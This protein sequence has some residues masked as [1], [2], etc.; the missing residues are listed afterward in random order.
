MPTQTSTTP[1]VAGFLPYAVVSSLQVVALW[2]GDESVALLTKLL[3]M[4]LLAVGVLWVRRGRS[5]TLVLLL[6]AIT[7]S[8]LGDSA[9]Q[10]FPFV[11][12][13]PMMLLFFGLAHLAYIWL[14]QRHTAVQRMPLW[15][16]VYAAWWVAMLAVLWPHLGDLRWAVAVY[17]LV[18]GGTAASSARCRPMIAGGGALFLASDTLLAFRLFVPDAM[19]WWTS[20]LVMLT[21]CLGQGLIA[22]GVV[23]SRKRRA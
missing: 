3:L 19:P 6:A 13:L 2:I 23:T 22:A 4:P 20:P 8:W 21:Y 12:S 16:L 11:P 5:A 17:G 10:F 1:R 9:A 7:L 14:F 18:L 15:A